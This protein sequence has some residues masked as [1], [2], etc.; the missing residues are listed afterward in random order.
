MA[1]NTEEK[2][3]LWQQ[4]KE[5]GETGKENLKEFGRKVADNAKSFGESVKNDGLFNTLGNGAI[6]I[7]ESLK[8][9]AIKMIK[10]AVSGIKHIVKKF[11]DNKEVA[12]KLGV[13]QEELENLE[14]VMERN[15]EMSTERMAAMVDCLSRLNDRITDFSPDNIN[16]FVE[17]I[18]KNLTEA[19][20]TLGETYV[21]RTAQIEEA[22]NAVIPEEFQ[23]NY[24]VFIVPDKE[25]GVSKA[26]LS[27]G[28]DSHVTTFSIERKGNTVEFKALKGSEVE[29][30]EWVKQR[31]IT[32]NTNGVSGNS[33]AALVKFAYEEC[34]A[35]ELSSAAQRVAEFEK[36]KNVLKN[37]G[38][39]LEREGYT[40]KYDKEQHS[41]I[42]EQDNGNRLILNA[43]PTTLQA[44]FQENPED[45]L[46]PVFAI[47]R[48]EEENRGVI[49]RTEMNVPSN[50]TN[51]INDLLSVPE[52]NTILRAYNGEKLPEDLRMKENGKYFKTDKSGKVRLEELKT[53]LDMSSGIEF[54]AIEKGDRTAIEVALTGAKD[55]YMITFTPDGKHI[56]YD[57]VDSKGNSTIISRTGGIVDAVTAESENFKELNKIVS[58]AMQKVNE[59][60]KDLKKAQGRGETLT[61]DEKQL[62][63][64][65]EFTI[66]KNNYR[67]GIISTTNEER[68]RPFIPEYN[69]QNLREELG[70]DKFNAIL[71]NAKTVIQ[72]FEALTTSPDGETEGYYKEL[73]GMPKESQQVLAE[74][75]GKVIQ[76]G[77]K[78]ALNHNTT[79]ADE[80][81]R[82][83]MDIA[84]QQVLNGKEAHQILNINAFATAYAEAVFNA[85]RTDR[86]FAP[87]ELGTII[88]E[89]VSYQQNLKYDREPYGT[90]PVEA[91]YIPVEYQ[92]TEEMQEQVQEQENI[93]IMHSELSKKRIDVFSKL[94][95]GIKEGRLSTSAEY[96]ELENEILEGLRRNGMINGFGDSYTMD[97]HIAP[98]QIND[99]LE[100]FILSYDNKDLSE[101]LVADEL[102]RLLMKKVALERA[103]CEAVD[104]LSNGG[105]IENVELSNAIDAF[106]QK[107]TGIYSLSSKTNPEVTEEILKYSQEFSEQYCR[108]TLGN[109]MLSPSVKNTM[110]AP[111]VVVVNENR[112]TS[113]E[114][115]PSEIQPLYAKVMLDVYLQ[116]PNVDDMEAEMIKNG[117][118]DYAFDEDLFKDIQK[119][120]K[121]QHNLH[122]ENGKPVAENDGR[123]YDTTSPEIRAVFETNFVSEQFP[124]NPNALEQAKMKTPDV[125]APTVE[126]KQ[127]PVE[128]RQEEPVQEQTE[129]ENVPSAP[130]DKREEVSAD[131]Y[132][133]L[134]EYIKEGAKSLLIAAVEFGTL[135]NRC[136]IYANSWLRQYDEGMQH[137]LGYKNVEILNQL[138]EQLEEVID[139][140]KDYLEITGDMWRGKEYHFSPQALAIIENVSEQC[141]TE[142]YRTPETPE[143]DNKPAPDYPTMD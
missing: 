130:E 32:A 73:R 18:Q 42:C 12:R 47:N 67:Q 66:A 31:T 132:Q 99:F 80:K 141:L 78:N 20:D 103:Y 118:G 3:N 44:Y 115:V 135:N 58:K 36:L 65:N 82:K 69:E 54:R 71:E 127:Q 129:P 59:L 11:A 60:I 116:N 128:T 7:A 113:T 70:D 57:Y 56:G 40:I 62:V 84:F 79:I 22:L 33:L 114:P 26:I 122:F 106:V 51:K 43:T 29:N 124:D 92:T 41:F 53:Q 4:V 5:S 102:S 121:E 109:N 138:L 98:E 95:E 75:A 49:N 72:Q 93:A 23:S 97:S 28:S 107:K 68:S 39:S 25:T 19:Y 105:R 90:A 61:E 126:E 112:E 96:S 1:E 86:K 133:K 123:L 14:D 134:K 140:P 110:E 88:L 9:L 34:S 48:I 77:A 142:L 10:N 143:K 104:I 85:N 101:T 74:S 63:N 16:Q 100:G 21:I 55:K 17:E 24:K 87:V 13:L 27:T 125:P 46:K 139:N 117:Y 8:N 91:E 15:N 30:L 6:G 45:T 38:D 131:E 89:D 50:L 83:I 81:I 37:E 119:F 52:M 76:D 111:P 136:Q 120:A 137:I 35:K 2:K 64:A 108:S 94:I